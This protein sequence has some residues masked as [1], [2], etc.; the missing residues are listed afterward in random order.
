LKILYGS[1]QVLFEGQA[2]YDAFTNSYWSEFQTEPDPYCIF[3][4]KTGTD[5]SIT[6][7]ISRLTQCP[8]AAKSGGHAAFAGASSIEGGITVSFELMKSVTLSKDKKIAA[9]EPG[10]RWGEVYD[11][12]AGTGVVVIGGRI[13]VCF[14]SL[15]FAQ[16]DNYRTLE[17][18]VLLPVAESRSSRTWSAGRVITL[19]A[20]M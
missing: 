8:F 10:N 17:L 20:T 1:S 9:V 3:K 7:L 13:Y 12:L 18:V 19:P 4:P 15:M 5:V 2:G 6:V 14:L 11:K 16:S